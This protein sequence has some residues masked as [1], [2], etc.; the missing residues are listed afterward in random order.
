M[1]D[2]IPRVTG[3][4]APLAMKIA[5]GVIAAL[6]AVVA[7][8]AWRA[9]SLSDA[10]DD[11]LERLGAAETRHAITQASLEALMADM[12]AMVEEGRLTAERRDEAVAEARQ[13]GDA[14]RRQAD[15]VEAGE[16]DYMDVEGI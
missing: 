7:F 12:A 6:L 3:I 15:A 14:L 4:F 16:V 13:A 8:Y 1:G 11:A 9:D 5:A 2:I 10:R